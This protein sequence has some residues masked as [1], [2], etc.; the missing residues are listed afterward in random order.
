ML[1]EERHVVITWVTPWSDF[2]GMY[3]FLSYW[4][5]GVVSNQIYVILYSVSDKEL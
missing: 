5:K 2:P 3:L 4:E 1:N